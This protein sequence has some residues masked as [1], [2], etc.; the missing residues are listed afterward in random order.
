MGIDNDK[1]VSILLANKYDL[2]EEGEN[3]NSVSKEEIV[4]LVN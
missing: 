4:K 3:N 1:Y 2:V